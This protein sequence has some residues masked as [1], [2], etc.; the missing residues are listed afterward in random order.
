MNRIAEAKYFIDL[1]IEKVKKSIKSGYTDSEILDLMLDQQK[2][3]ER[4]SQ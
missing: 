4:L 2:A 1:A 3:I